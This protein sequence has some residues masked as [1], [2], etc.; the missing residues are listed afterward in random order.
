MS[1]NLPTWAECS[2]EQHIRAGAY[3]SARAQFVEATRLYTSAFQRWAAECLDHPEAEAE[4]DYYG[5]D[6]YAARMAAA[7]AEAIGYASAY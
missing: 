7:Q 3:R 4:R 6:K 5:I 1:L 2:I